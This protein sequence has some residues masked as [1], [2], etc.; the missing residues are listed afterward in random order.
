MKRKVTTEI[1]IEELVAAT[2]G[3]GA[4][5]R[6]KHVYRESLRALVRLAKSERMLEVKAS[7]DRLTGSIAA[8]AAR[9][10]AKALLN[11]Q[12]AGGTETVQQQLEFDQR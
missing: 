5:A 4:T 10:E 8:R 11:A 9:R 1:A 3:E 7:V 2:C 12:R 6:E